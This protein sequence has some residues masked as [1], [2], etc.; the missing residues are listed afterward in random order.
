MQLPPIRT[1]PTPN[2]TDNLFTLPL[3][4]PSSHSLNF[5]FFSFPTN[6]HPQSCPRPLVSSRPPDPCHALVSST[7]PATHLA[8]KLHMIFFVPFPRPPSPR[9]PSH[10]AHLDK[11]QCSALF[12]RGEITLR[13]ARPRHTRPPVQCARGI[14]DRGILG[15][16]P[17]GCGRESFQV[18][19]WWR[20]GQI[21][22]KHRTRDV[23]DDSVDGRAD[24]VDEGHEPCICL[25]KAENVPRQGQRQGR[26]GVCEQEACPGTVA[27]RPRATRRAQI[28]TCREPGTC[29]CR[30]GTLS[31][32]CHDKIA[33]K[34]KFQDKFGRDGPGPLGY[35]V[36]M[37][38]KGITLLSGKGGRGVS[39]T[40][41]AK[42]ARPASTGQSSIMSLH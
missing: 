22:P 42:D 2:C 7:T 39:F 20:V 34:F 17:Q 37:T 5:S 4:L 24:L 14:R 18:G 29:A 9:P 40:K 28:A 15:Y 16:I 19:I 35:K 10:V 6:A 3:T 38:Y 41:G 12:H 31:R 27:G 8:C 36:S 21:K 13:G 1:S 30:P 33:S 23:R 26:P 11:G 25:S 32:R